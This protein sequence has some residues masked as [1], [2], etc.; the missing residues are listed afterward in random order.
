M[1][2]LLIATLL[3]AA[4]LSTT[5]CATK[6]Y[7]RQGQVTVAEKQI[8]TCREIAI[9]VAKVDGYLKQVDHESSFDILSIASFLGDFGIGNA[10]EHNAALK[11]AAKRSG[12]LNMLWVEKGCTTGVMK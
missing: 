12:Q 7:G 10:I 3:I 2:Q 4:T 8:L 6:S 5:G 11:S 1:K 9:E